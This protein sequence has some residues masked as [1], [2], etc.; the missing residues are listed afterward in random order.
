MTTITVMKPTEKWLSLKKFHDFKTP[1]EMAESYRK[2]G[3]QEG[4]PICCI[5]E[6]VRD[7]V[8]GESPGELRGGK[9]GFVPCEKCK[10]G[11]WS[12]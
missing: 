7:S 3:I 12:K 4:Y 9:D 6:F 10:K 8:A 5:E 1:E 11:G 2:R